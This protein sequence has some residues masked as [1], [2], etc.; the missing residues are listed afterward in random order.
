MST[1]WDRTARRIEADAIDDLRGNKKLQSPAGQMFVDRLQEL[2]SE[3]TAPLLPWLAREYRKGRLRHGNDLEPT[4]LRYVEDDSLEPAEAD[5]LMHYHQY[6]IGALPEPPAHGLD[7]NIPALYKGIM[8]DTPHPS[9]VGSKLRYTTDPDG[10]YLKDPPERWQHLQ[11]S[12]LNHWADWFQQPDRRKV[13]LDQLKIHELPGEVKRYEHEKARNV[14]DE[15]VEEGRWQGEPV[16]TWPDGWAIHKLPAGKALDFEAWHMRGD[17]DPRDTSNPHGAPI[18]VN[19]PNYQSNVGSGSTLIYSLRDPQGKP[20]VTTEIDPQRASHTVFGPKQVENALK[21]DPTFS[22]WSDEGKQQLREYMHAI[23]YMPNAH[24]GT[25]FTGD[26]DRDSD[27]WTMGWDLHQH[28]SQ[29]HAVPHEGH[30]VQIQ[31]RG[32]SVAK[33]EYQ[34]RMKDWFST[35]SPDERPRWGNDGDDIRDAGD[36]R[37]WFENRDNPQAADPNGMGGYGPHGDYGLVALPPD[38][39][40][41]NMMDTVFNPGPSGQESYDHDK[42]RALYQTALERG[43]IPEFAKALEDYQQEA[44]DSFDRWMDM[45]Y[46]IAPQYPE[47]DEDEDA[48]ERYYD[49]RAEWESEH[50]GMEAVKSFYGMVKP[51]WNAEQ[52]AYLNPVAAHPTTFSKVQDPWE[53]TARVIE[54][55]AMADLEANKKFRSP[56]GQA[57]LAELRRLHTDKTAE[58]IPWLAREFRKGRLK[59]GNDLEDMLDWHPAAEGLTEGEKYALRD[60]E[61]YHVGAEPEPPPL[62]PDVLYDL[63]TIGTTLPEL[64]HKL[65]HTGTGTNGLWHWDHNG[66]GWGVTNETL[67]H[68]KDWYD[69]PDRRNVPLEQ[70][71]IGDMRRE[72][73]QYENEK[74][75]RMKDEAVEEGRHQGEV[76]HDYPDGWTLRKLPHGKALDFEAWH[77]RGD[78]TEENPEGAPICVNWPNYQ[79]EVEAGHTHIY[80]LRDPRGKPHVTMELEPTYFERVPRPFDLE[81]QMDKHPVIRHLPEDGKQQ[82]RALHSL[83]QQNGWDTEHFR[84]KLKGHYKDAPA[85]SNPQEQWDGLLYELY[86][87]HDQRDRT[88]PVHIGYPENGKLKQIQ[89]RG[90]SVPKPEYQAR[91]K[92]WFTRFP[93][94]QRPDWDRGHD[95]AIQHLGEIDGAPPNVK[96]AYNYM[97]GDQGD[98]GGYGPHGDYGL[99]SREKDVRWDN[100]TYHLTDREAEWTRQPVEEATALYNFARQRGALP[101]LGHA[102]FKQPRYDFDDATDWQRARQHWHEANDSLMDQAPPYPW[103]GESYIPNDPS[104]DSQEQ[105]QEARDAFDKHEQWL[106]SGV[107][108]YHAALT[109]QNLMAPH[110]HPEAKVYGNEVYQPPQATFAK[111]AASPD[112]RMLWVFSPQH[113]RVHLYNEAD[114]HPADA[115]T[116]E[117]IAREHGETGLT[118]GYAYT[119]PNGWRIFD[120][121][122]KPV[123]DP[124]VRRQVA[125]ALTKRNGTP[126]P[127]WSPEVISRFHYGDP[128]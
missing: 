89:G 61:R 117:S 22:T 113:G 62:A 1:M 86:R 3:K 31:G 42:G 70:L 39:N 13:P 67:N 58:M 92:Q 72:L 14:K 75:R 73:E 122:H 25:P 11:E 49:E 84:E 111:V 97:W 81:H 116:H 6:H 27:L 126:Q 71:K 106:M 74:A 47:D 40:Y 94:G 112:V 110:W 8:H 29:E 48:M 9:M 63:D 64:H 12:A 88:H 17:A 5:A 115:P 56:A 79:S 7:R 23:N 65:K 77:M 21:T 95:T 124:F 105:W 54:A 128:I 2:H 127:T 43:E 46:S 68:W 44:Q 108:T 37:D 18:C 82:L 93:E 60:Y 103:P 76:V 50:P 15:S 4:L 125:E 121:D 36:V 102:M 83:A 123:A 16:H 80:S 85:G 19:W 24:R 99:D 69:Q 59:H 55:D 98:M 101:A 57:F 96:N 38:V 119:I 107:P 66:D 28:W 35:F 53:R 34:A 20:H 41:R 114:H 33:P 32:N 45:N 91:L 10:H 118:H 26:P 104:F 87:E 51:H 109:L 90:N 30:I 100:L 120:Y 52:N 78:P